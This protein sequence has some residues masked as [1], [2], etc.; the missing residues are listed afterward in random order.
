M[1]IWYR[2]LLRIFLASRRGDHIAGTCRW[3]THIDW[4]CTR[5]MLRTLGSS[6]KRCRSGV[7][8]CATRGMARTDSKPPWP[9]RRLYKERFGA[10]N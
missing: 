5:K 1:R 3:N 4:G 10:E 7:G 8:A 2:V 6:I 9:L